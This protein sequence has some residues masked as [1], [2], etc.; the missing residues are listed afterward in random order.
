MIK[1]V[2]GQ[3]EPKYKPIGEKK[4]MLKELISK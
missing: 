4:Q 1:A 3:P 2:Y